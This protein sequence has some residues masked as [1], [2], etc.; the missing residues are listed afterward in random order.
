[1]H[2]EWTASKAAATRK[3]RLHSTVKPFREHGT[4][5][6]VRDWGWEIVKQTVKETTKCFPRF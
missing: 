3:R 1:M 4:F 6:S 5:D 2:F